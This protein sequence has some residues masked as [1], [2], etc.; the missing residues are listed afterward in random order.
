[1]VMTTRKGDGEEERGWRGRERCDDD[2]GEVE[3]VVMMIRVGRYTHP[4]DNEKR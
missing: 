3:D 2:G 4:S 1:M